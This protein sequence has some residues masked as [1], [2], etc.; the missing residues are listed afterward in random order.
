MYAVESK[1]FSSPIVRPSIKFSILIGALWSP[2][3]DKIKNILVE[4]TVGELWSLLLA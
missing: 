4:H 3:P 1:R 2:L